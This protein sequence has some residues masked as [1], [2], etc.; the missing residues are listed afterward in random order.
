MGGFHGNPVQPGPT[1]QLPH[2]RPAPQGGTSA[3]EVGDGGTGTPPRTVQRG[4]G[5]WPEQHRQLGRVA[6]EGA[7]DRSDSV[8]DAVDGSH[9]CRVPAG[10]A[11]DPGGVLDSSQQRVDARVL[12]RR[13]NGTVCTGR[14]R[15]APACA[16][17]QGTTRAEGR[18]ADYS[19]AWTRL[20]VGG[21]ER[22][23][24]RGQPVQP[25]PVKHDPQVY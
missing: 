4:R 10:S 8:G 19:A 2:I 6:E 18:P 14:K 17:V 3:P 7:A 9:E 11:F 21:P 20:C 12:T 22:P 16:S 15:A 24:P 23:E 13:V 25:A 1:E 5:R